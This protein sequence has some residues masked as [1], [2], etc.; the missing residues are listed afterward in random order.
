MRIYF[1][2]PRKVVPEDR[3]TEAILADQ[4]CI[5]ELEGAEVT[6]LAQSGG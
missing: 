6:R 4:L 1:C 2:L 3:S 5:V